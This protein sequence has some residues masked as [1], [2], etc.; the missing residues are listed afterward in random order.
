MKPPMTELTLVRHGQAGATPENYDELSALGREQALRLGHWLLA[1]GREFAGLV[2]GRM[3]RQRETLAAICEVYAE[4][5]RPLPPAEELPGL[6]EYRFAEMVRAFALMH[7][8]HP[9]LAVVRERPTDKRLW[10]PLLRT[11]LSAWAAGTLATTTESYAEFQS[12]TRAALADIE[13]RLRAGPVLAVSS[14]GVMGQVAQRVLGYTDAVA[15]DVNLSLM[16]TAVCEYKA[17]RLGL[18][19]A[20][21]N[22]LPHLTAPAD[23]GLITLV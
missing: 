17:T 5:G 9:E 21:L 1:H 13:V 15:I 20:S 7:P 4:A 22:A 10:V 16:N 11:T 23:R 18:K 19:L 8:D 12:R 2:V 14:S 6:D 3:R